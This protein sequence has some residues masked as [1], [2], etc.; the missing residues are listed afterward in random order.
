MRPTRVSQVTIRLGDAPTHIRRT[1]SD[2]LSE[3]VLCQL[4]TS[5]LLDRRLG[6]VVPVVQAALATRT[7]HGEHFDSG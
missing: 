4:S 6:E 2:P 1:I 7:M 3:A 5:S